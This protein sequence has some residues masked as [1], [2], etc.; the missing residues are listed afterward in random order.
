[1]GVIRVDKIFRLTF[2]SKVVIF[3][4]RSEIKTV[5]QE[6]VL[7]PKELREQTIKDAKCALI[8]DAAHK[9]FSEKGYLNARLDDIAA[10]AGFS[11]PSLYSYYQ[12][13][14][15]IFLSLAVREMQNMAQ[16]IEAA[17]LA[18]AAFPVILE[19]ILRIMFANFAQ[20]FSYFSTVTNFQAL[21]AVQAEMSKHHELMGRFHEIMGRGL[22]SMEKVIKRAREKGEISNAQDTGGLSWFILSLIQGTHM[23]SWMTR[24]P[25]DV[26]SEVKH[27]IDF[28]MNG[29]AVKKTQTGKVHV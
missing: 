1:M 13:K 11:K 18:D 16:K 20:T 5:S 8:H 15:A 3:N 2:L 7:D 9:L 14:E 4:C 22:G 23:R 25:P 28:I 12:D 27:M 6:P 17:A 29:I 26:D 21:G 24:K 19:S 10:A